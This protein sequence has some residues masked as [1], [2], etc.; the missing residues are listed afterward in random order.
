MQSINGV[1]LGPPS[2]RSVGRDPHES[3]KERRDLTLSVSVVRM[4]SLGRPGFIL[5]SSVRW[6]FAVMC[7]SWSDEPT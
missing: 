2:V 4:S 6:G 3:R 1:K 5:D 7:F